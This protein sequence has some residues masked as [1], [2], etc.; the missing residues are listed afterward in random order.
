MMDKVS[1][2]MNERKD[3]LKSAGPLIGIA[4]AFIALTKLFGGKSKHGSAAFKE[5]S[6]EA[7]QHHHE[8]VH[9]THNRTDPDKGVGGWEHLTAE[10]SHLH[11]HAALDHSHRP[12]RDVEEEHRHEAHVHDHD[13]PTMS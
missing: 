12:H 7:L 4:V 6:H 2:K 3:M 9:V 11:N 8:H 1:D 10:H 13:H 5:H